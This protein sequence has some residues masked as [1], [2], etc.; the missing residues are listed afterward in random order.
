MNETGSDYRPNT[1]RMN[2]RVPRDLADA[3]WSL[4]P[5][6]KSDA[7]RRVLMAGLLALNHYPTPQG[8]HM[9]G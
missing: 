2:T 9:E 5:Q 7:L 4:N 1:V 6:N 8:G 3:V